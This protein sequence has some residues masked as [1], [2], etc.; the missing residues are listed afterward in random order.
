[1][2]TALPTLALRCLGLPS[3]RVN[4]GEPPPEVVWRKHLAL[5]TYLVLSPESTRT[6]S[7]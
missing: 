3:A 5:L 1:M 2:A 4:G 7:H 6:R